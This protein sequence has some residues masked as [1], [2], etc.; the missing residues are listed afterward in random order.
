MPRTL[1]AIPVFCLCLSAAR[2]QLPVQ[3]FELASPR[4]AWKTRGSLY[5]H[6]EFLDSRKDSTMI[7]L[8]Q[9][10]PLNNLDARLVFKTPAQPQ[11]QT[12]L[13]ALIDSTAGD[14]TLL[15]Q[16]RD[17]RFVE[18][19]GSRYVFIKATLYARKDSG[20]RKIL[21]LDDHVVL[22]NQYILTATTALGNGLIDACIDS[23][24]TLPLTGKDLYSMRDLLHIDS[25]EEDKLPVYRTDRFTDGVY[26]NFSSFCQQ[27]PDRQGWFKANRDGIV[28]SVHILDENAGKI[29]LK[30]KNAYAVV[31][32]GK[33][34]IATAFGYYPLEKVRDN[35]FFTGDI[36][37]AA[38]ANDVV[39]G[40]FAF[41]LLGAIDNAVGFRKTYDIIIDP[42][43]GQFIHLR[44][45]PKTDSP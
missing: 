20:F 22:R 44:E 9:I 26:L 42:E 6:I 34:F 5:R 40:Q 41:G 23:A 38:T 13:S 31:Y 29:R 18:S 35:F 1:L 14:G 4:A 7:G 10:G 24:L 27:T 15:F 12:L 33:P 28:S 36:H 19:W 39:V 45:I 16:L 3:Y 21:T 8:V 37:I 43:N 25:V 2:A 11:L 30:P 17:F 32:R